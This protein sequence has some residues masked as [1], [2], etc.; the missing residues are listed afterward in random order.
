MRRHDSRNP[1]GVDACVSARTWENNVKARPSLG[2]G[3]TP[4]GG[5]GYF[6]ARNVSCIVGAHEVG[7]SRSLAVS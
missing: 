7:K 4:A 1:D 6:G 5:S 2:P 3:G